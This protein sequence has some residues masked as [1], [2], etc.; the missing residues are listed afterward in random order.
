M[1]AGDAQTLDPGSPRARF[2]QVET[3]VP[4]LGL[5]GSAHILGGSSVSLPARK[6]DMNRMT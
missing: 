4:R 5:D 2:L 3:S 1:G 6:R